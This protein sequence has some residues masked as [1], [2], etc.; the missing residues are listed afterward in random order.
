MRNIVDTINQILAI[1]PTT[2]VTYNLIQDL[3]RIRDRASFMPP[4]ISYKAWEELHEKVVET[5]KP[6]EFQLADW[7]LEVI[8]ILTGN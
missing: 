7:E 5:F 2:R 1:V 3:T 4:E 8:N 6:E